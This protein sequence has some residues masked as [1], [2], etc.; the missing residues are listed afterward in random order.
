MGSQRGTEGM[1]GD[2]GMLSTALPSSCIGFPAWVLGFTRAEL[3]RS[4]G[5]SAWCL[6][7]GKR[8]LGWHGWP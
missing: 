1:G 6:W 7:G 5:S 8:V 3:L 4:C 2:R